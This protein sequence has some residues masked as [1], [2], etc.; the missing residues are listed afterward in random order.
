MSEVSSFEELNARKGD[1]VRRT[2]K[3]SAGSGTE[4]IEIIDFEIDEVEGNGYVR[5]KSGQA[6]QVNTYQNRSLDWV[7]LERAEIEEP[8]MGSYIPFK[9]PVCEGGFIRYVGGY[10]FIEGLKIPGRHVLDHQWHGV[11]TNPNVN[12]DNI[13][14]P[15]D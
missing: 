10:Q 14:T 5:A 11:K 6:W 1:R 3:W 2:K 12:F 4:I 15:T 9:S 13:V 8:P 7:M